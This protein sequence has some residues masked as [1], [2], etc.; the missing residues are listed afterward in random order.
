MVNLGWINTYWALI[1]PSLFGVF[2][3]FFLRQFFLS[4]PK[5]LEEAAII[6]G[7]SRWQILWRILLPNSTAALATVAIISFKNEWNVFLWP[8]VVI[9]DYEKMPIQV[10]LAYFRSGVSDSWGTLL[11][12]AV[13]AL[14][15]LILVFIFF[16]RYFVSSA[17]TT[18][19]AGK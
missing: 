14:V 3:T 7:C 2:N 1:I 6:D 9:N 5:E 19:L 18:G 13:I 8:L 4:F 16:Q 11:A 17:L 12:G 10:G 15:P